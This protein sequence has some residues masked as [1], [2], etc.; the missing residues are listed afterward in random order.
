MHTIAATITCFTMTVGFCSQ[1]STEQPKEEEIIR[2]ND[3]AWS[4]AL[5]NK[6]LDKVMTNYAEDASFL[7]PD[8]PIVLLSHDHH[9]DNLDHTGRSVLGKARAVFTTAEGAARLAGNSRGLKDWQAVDLP[10]PNQRMLCIVATPAR[11]GARGRRSWSG[12]WIH[13]VLQR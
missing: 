6:D 3:A 7:V 12:D 10:A 2:E 1:A 9:F 13:P 8:E 5:T 11:H 4:E